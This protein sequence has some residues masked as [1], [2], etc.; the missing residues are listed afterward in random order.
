MDCFS[1]IA[2]IIKKEARRETGKALEWVPALLGTITKTGLKLDI[3][4]HEI[5]DYLVSHHLTLNEPDF[6]HTET[7]GAHGQPDAGFG[8]A[9]VNQVIT[10]TELLPLH[11][12]DRV[13][14]IPVNNGQTFVVVARVVPQNA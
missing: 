12:G 6:T 4:K 8:G 1:E 7:D 11:P 9:H 3:Y 2:S 10:P 13:L 5:R 14:V